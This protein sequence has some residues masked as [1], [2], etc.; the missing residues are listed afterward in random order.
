[1]SDFEKFAKSEFG[2]GPM[3][4]HRYSTAT[5]SYINPTIIEERKLNAS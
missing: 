3:T 4:L 2:V 1:M 5:D